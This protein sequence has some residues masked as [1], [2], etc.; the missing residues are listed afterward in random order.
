MQRDPDNEE[1]RL[2]ERCLTPGAGDVLEVGCGPGRLTAGMARLADTLLALDTDS[3]DLVAARARVGASTWLAAASG[4]ALPLAAGRMDSV[5][6]TL[7]LHHQDPVKALAEARRVLRARGRVLVLEP[8]A[9]CLLS[10]LFAVL[11]DETEK[12]DRAEKAIARSGLQELE[13]G[14][15]CSRWVFADSAD[16]QID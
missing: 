5:V 2:I 10:R 1:A 8:R 15:V 4:E 3:G 16:F 6:F 7:S 12:Y 11:D 9:D 14:S 13:T